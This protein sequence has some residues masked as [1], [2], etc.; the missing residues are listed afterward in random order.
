MCG[1]KSQ[2]V[3]QTTIPPEVMARYNAVNLRAEDVAKQ[4]FQRYG[5]EF[6]APLTATQQAGIGNV[7]QSAG[8]AQGAF[9]QAQGIQ[10]SAYNQASPYLQQASQAANTGY[11][12]ASNQFGQ[13]GGYLTNAA[14]QGQIY[15]GEAYQPIAGALSATQ[16]YMQQATGLVTGG[17]GAA[18]PMMGAAEGYLGG[19][20]QAIGPQEFGQ[21]QIN[22]YMSPYM[23]NVVE[24]QQALQLQEN[25][26][27]RNAL[28][29]QA[30]GAGAFGGDRA[31]ISQANLARQQSLANQA[32]L[33][34]LLQQGYGQAA[35]MFQQQQGVNL[36]AAQAN[37]AAQQFGSQQAANLAQQRY[38]QQMG[39]G[40]QLAALGQQQFG[41]NIGAGQ[42]LAGLGQQMYQQGLGA[43]QAAQGLGSAQYGMGAQQAG[44]MQGLGQAQFGMQ[45]QQAMNLA[46][47][48]AQQ[49]AAALQGA[50]A[51]IGA[52]TLE[53]Q[54]K[55]AEDTARYNEF[56][57]ERGFPYQ[58]AQF[59]AN[60]AMGTGALSGSTTTTTSP[61]AFFSDRRLKKDIKEIGETHDGLPIYS[62]KYKG[63]DDQPRIGVMADEARE[64]H[65]D[66][67]KRVGGVDAV[68]YEK[69]AN[70]AS[71][72]GGVMP[73][74]AGEGF[75][76][77]GH[78][79]PEDLSAILAMQR[80]FLGPYAQG[81]LYGQSSQNLPGGKGV[82]PLASLPVARPPKHA[83]PPRQQ[84][85]GISQAVNL[86]DKAEGIY[87]RGKKA[88]A[89][90][91]PPKK[92]PQPSAENNKEPSG[93]VKPQDSNNEKPNMKVASVDMD[94]ITPRD[95]DIYVPTLYAAR[96]GVVPHKA[97]GGTLQEKVLP[98]Q[99]EDPYGVEAVNEAESGEKYDLLGED[100]GKKSGS[101]GG[102]GGNPAIKLGLKAAALGANFIPGVGPFLSAGLSGASSLFNEGGTVR[103]AY[104]QGGVRPEMSDEEYAIR[105]AAAE[106]TGD[107]D[108]TRGIAHVIHNR[109]KSGTYGNTYKDVVLAPKQFEPWAT[110]NN[111]PMNISPE[112]PRYKAAQSA[113]SDIQQGNFDP[114][115]ENVQNFW[116]PRSQYALGRQAPTW[117]RVGGLDL[118]GT[119]FHTLDEVAQSRADIEPREFTGV[120]PRRA[121]A[122]GIEGEIK[123]RYSPDG[124]PRR[125]VAGA[126]YDRDTGKSY[127]DGEPVKEGLAAYLPT[128]YRTGKQ[129][130]S[131]GDYLTD[132]QFIRP[133]LAGLAGMAQSKSRFAVP[134]ILEGLG[135][136]AMADVSG[137]KTQQEIAES[138]S[139]EAVQLSQAANNAVFQIGPDTWAVRLKNGQPKLLADWILTQEE[140][141]GGET[142]ALLAKQIYARKSGQQPGSTTSAAGSAGQAGSGATTGAIKDRSAGIT[143]PAFVTYDDQ[144]RK[145]ATSDLQSGQ[146][147]RAFKDNAA[148]QR[149]LIT[150]TANAAY[151]LSPVLTGMSQN[152][153]STLANTAP[154]TAGAGFDWAATGTAVFNS[155]AR[156]FGLKDANGS[157]ITFGPQDE[158]RDLSRKYQALIATMAS[159]GAG[160][161]TLGALQT[162]YEAMPQPNM[163]PGAQAKLAAE[164]T[165]F[166][167][168]DIHRADFLN[169]YDKDSYDTPARANAEFERTNG[170]KYLAAVDIIKD[171]I[172]YQPKAY[173]AMTRGEISP[174][175]TEKYFKMYAEKRGKKYYPGMST[176][177]Y[178][179]Q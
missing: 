5:G 95:E 63:G 151:D 158:Q 179:G 123:A 79:S 89:G 138:Q 49:Q 32:T 139:R 86:Y 15:G 80:Q 172:Q 148:N 169:K 25:A 125:Q 120:V 128:N 47:L 141:A 174:E 37:R 157:P 132:R 131:V 39:A 34:G 41:Q 171:F 159:K 165:V 70:R 76:E 107:P 35:N 155:L 17:L 149:T 19:G 12:Q 147:S 136:A 53:Q 168:K 111:N 94:S 173:I 98:Y 154:G 163:A 61:N 57:Q 143:L 62:F 110:K 82:V 83:A 67:V 99:S 106:T 42:A 8:L 166:N 78:V 142:S 56:L 43:S 105:T 109:L 121:G 29:A 103:P 140:L 176:L 31:G 178:G 90:L 135:A 69:I 130:E 124:Q 164:L 24:A 126:Q 160:G 40:Q 96:G 21:A 36:A 92:D 108:E 152:V 50:Q 162:M 77:G 13:A 4:P 156:N 48:G 74:R 88:Y 134:A 22:K 59:L 65:P 6:V 93:G 58:V 101:S 175:E 68:D 52:G 104:Q 51:Q 28:N 10:Q 16:P 100:E 133:V 115:F 3:Q 1:G 146:S 20:T 91:N 144:T 117:G 44:L 113:F 119:R 26:A 116:G 66:A 18:A 72:G 150:N 73:H 85:G 161:N 114:R 30:I 55:Q 118:G 38:A 27:Q 145:Q 45:S 2:T 127:I 64:K 137:E 14:S 102:K 153:A 129:F 170:P 11:G 87:Q 71:E 97:K 167:K 46:N 60:I 122:G 7:N 9:N 84:E 54:T 81:G 23:R 75:A 112:D 33:G 177:I